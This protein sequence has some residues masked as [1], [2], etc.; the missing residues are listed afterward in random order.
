M[1]QLR[2]YSNQEGLVAF[3]HGQVK[4]RFRQFGGFLSEF[5]WPDG[6]LRDST[7]RAVGS[8]RLKEEEVDRP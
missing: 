1:P 5:L 7:L 3:W 6:Y 4:W 8:H 2:E